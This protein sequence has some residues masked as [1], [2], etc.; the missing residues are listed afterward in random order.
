M[1]KK[2][3]LTSE[4]AAKLLH[5]MGAAWELK[6]GITKLVLQST[7]TTVFFLYFGATVTSG[8]IFNTFENFLEW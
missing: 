6:E 2:K 7:W 5:K 1:V 8:V 3:S 4:H